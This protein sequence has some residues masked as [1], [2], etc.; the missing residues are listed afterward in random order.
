MIKFNKLAGKVSFSCLKSFLF[1]VDVVAFLLRIKCNIITQL[2]FLFG[3]NKSHYFM[4]YSFGAR[5]KQVAYMHFFVS[6][7]ITRTTT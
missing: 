2:K 6:V 1:V 4:A 3:V 7:V 5:F